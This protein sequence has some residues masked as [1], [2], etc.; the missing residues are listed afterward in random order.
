MPGAGDDRVG[1]VPRRQVLSG[2]PTRLL[3]LLMTAGRGRSQPL[4]SHPKMRLRGWLAYPEISFCRSQLRV[5][6]KA[7]SQAAHLARAG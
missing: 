4:P 6:P 2:V 1:G 7:I 3:F 5:S